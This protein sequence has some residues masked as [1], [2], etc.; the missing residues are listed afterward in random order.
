[1]LHAKPPAQKGFIFMPEIM[2]HNDINTYII[3]II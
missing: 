1:M 3:R 2:Y